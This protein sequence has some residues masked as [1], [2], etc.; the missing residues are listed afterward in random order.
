MSGLRIRGSP[1]DH[2]VKGA[3][4][5]ILETPQGPV[6]YTGDIRM[7]GLHARKTLEF[8]EKARA[9]RPYILFMEGTNIDERRGRWTTEADVLRNARELIASFGKKFAIADFG[10]RN[11]E[12]LEIFLEAARESRRRLVVTT[13]DAYLLHAMRTVDPATPAPG[14]DIL[15]YDSPKGVDLGWE[16]WVLEQY[17]SATVRPEAIRDSP[18]DYLVAFSF[19]DIK[20]LVD[21]R[22]DGG[23]YIYSSSEAF[24][25][26]MEIDFKRLNA[27]L[28]KF[29]LERHGFDF[30]RDGSPVFPSG[31]EGL[32]SS[33]HAPAH[34][35]EELARRI[36]PEVLVPVHTER[37]EAFETRFGG[38]FRVVRPPRGRWVEI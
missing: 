31:P 8:I 22:P 12:R 6:V 21:L 11:I 9:P 28:T 4:G 7:H 5:A 27:W 1:V 38:E 34:H 10:P 25:E 2:S 36:N 20:H 15:I 14:D 16:E 18:G 30:D 26:E 35:L 24:N 29:G 19:F 13:K 37:P 23:H 33:G 32:H 3:V 17:S